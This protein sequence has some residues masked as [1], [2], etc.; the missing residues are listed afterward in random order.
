MSKLVADYHNIR[1][2]FVAIDARKTVK[3]EIISIIDDRIKRIESM[4]NS[5]FVHVRDELVVL[6]KMIEEK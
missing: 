2:K 1:D 5:T 4:M 3:K 6:K